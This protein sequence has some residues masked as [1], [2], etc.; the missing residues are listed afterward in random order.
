MVAEQQHPLA[1]VTNWNA[2]SRKQARRKEQRKNHTLNFGNAKQAYMPIAF[3]CKPQKY[4]YIYSLQSQ[5]KDE[6]QVLI[7]QLPIKY[8]LLLQLL[9]LFGFLH[10]HLS[11]QSD[12]L[13]KNQSLWPT[14]AFVHHCLFL[15]PTPQPSSAQIIC[16][17]MCSYTIIYIHVTS[18]DFSCMQY[19]S[20][21]DFLLPKTWSFLCVGVLVMSTGNNICIRLHI[22]FPCFIVSAIFFT[23]SGEPIFCMFV[24]LYIIIF[25]KPVRYTLCFPICNPSHL[26]FTFK[27]FYTFSIFSYMI[28]DRN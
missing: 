23:H 3:A 4:I 13:L 19:R 1:E 18:S 17:Y 11:K 6:M 26:N 25:S 12:Y 9:G 28:G 24:S 22:L 20:F 21:F 2:L 27:S 15:Q 7:K 5:Q 14:Q 16:I 8:T 10:P